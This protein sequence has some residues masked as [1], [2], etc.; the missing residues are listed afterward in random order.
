MLIGYW[1]SEGATNWP[2]PSQF[3]DETWDADERDTIADY[4]D[5]GLVTRSYMGY[6]PC[7]ICGCSNGALEMTDGT[8]VWPEGLAHYL[9]E[10]GVRPPA[11]FVV[12]VLE[13]VE[14]L[15]ETTYD[16]D[17]WRSLA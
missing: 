14:N 7:R 5:S 3:V 8:Y 10:H 11:V 9:R 16:E 15:F 1:A 4:L 12:H 6:S 2:S 17:W 13:M